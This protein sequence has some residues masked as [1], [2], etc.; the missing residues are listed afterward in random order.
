MTSVLSIMPTTLHCLPGTM[1]MF[2]EGPPPRPPAHDYFHH[3]REDQ[4]LFAPREVLRPEWQKGLMQAAQAA[5]I[6]DTRVTLCAG[7]SLGRLLRPRI[8][9]AEIEVGRLQPGIDHPFGRLCFPEYLYTYQPK[10]P[11]EELMHRPVLRSSTM[12][13]PLIPATTQMARC[14][15]TTYA[16]FNDLPVSRFSGWVELLRMLAGILNPRVRS[17]KTST[18]RLSR[19]HVWIQ[20]E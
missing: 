16:M 2:R 13:S 17:K 3:S 18:L 11:V 9:R 4:R 10:K 1:H 19:T 6:A 8:S 7:L 20:W 5:L 15:K 12:S 14:T